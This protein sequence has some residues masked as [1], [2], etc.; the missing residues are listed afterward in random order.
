MTIQA[1]SAKN[2]LNR[3]NPSGNCA[4][5]QDTYIW[6]GGECAAITALRQHLDRLNLDPGMIDLTVYWTQG[7]VQPL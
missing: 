7:S 2:S 6:A 3:L 4:V 1:S 5:G